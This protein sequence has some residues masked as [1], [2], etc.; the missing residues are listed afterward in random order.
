LA[1]AEGGVVLEGGVGTSSDAPEERRRGIPVSLPSQPHPPVCSPSHLASSP[2]PLCPLPSPSV[3]T[4]RY[5]LSQDFPPAAL[6]YLLGTAVGALR[7]SVRLG[8]RSSST[9]P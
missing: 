8:G 6:V 4:R 9:T 2:A 3:H 1:R 7:G 5:I